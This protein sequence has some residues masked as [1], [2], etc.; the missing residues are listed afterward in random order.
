MT[1]DEQQQPGFVAAGLEKFRAAT[2][3][4]LSH[5]TVSFADLERGIE[6][7]LAHIHDMLTSPAPPP[8]ADVPPGSADSAPSAAPAAP[9]GQ[10][11]SG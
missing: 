6:S 1:V 10:E 9:E 5:A 2:A 4:R 3:E 8:A 7:V 11:A